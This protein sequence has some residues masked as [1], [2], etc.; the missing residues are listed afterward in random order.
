LDQDTRFL[1]LDWLNFEKFMM[2][3][4]PSVSHEESQRIVY[5]ADI[6]IKDNAST[7]YFQGIFDSDGYLRLEI[8]KNMV[9]NQTNHNSL[10]ALGWHVNSLAHEP[11]NYFVELDINSMDYRNV[12]IVRF[13]NALGEG[14]GLIP[15]DI[16][17]KEIDVWAEALQVDSRE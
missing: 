11:E 10:I 2:K 7:T 5:V 3:S 15:S 6:G 9:T 12:S 4:L 14:L 1:N 17:V 13:R 8:S 16:E